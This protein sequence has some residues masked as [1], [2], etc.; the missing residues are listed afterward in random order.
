MPK[1]SDKGQNMPASPIRKLVPFA[2]QAKKNG[3]RIYH[4]N[5]GQPD[6]ETPKVMLDAIHS[7]PAKVVEY[8]HSAGNESYRRKLT[9]YYQK[10]DIALDYT[11]I[12]ITTGGSEAIE[13]AMMSVVFLV[14]KALE[15]T[16]ANTPPKPVCK[17][18]LVAI[19]ILMRGIRN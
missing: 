8:S 16:H 1:I 10:Y 14:V 2:E 4:L 12:M 9:G 17:C 11:D 3:I 7:Y 15:K 18:D 6:I 5:I 19:N 13:I